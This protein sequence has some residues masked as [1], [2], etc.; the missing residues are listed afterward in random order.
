MVKWKTNAEEI[1]GLAR[2][3]NIMTFIII[4]ELTHSRT[5]QLEHI[6]EI[7]LQ[8]LAWDFENHS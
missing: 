1:V 8:P 4:S 7:K 3:V 2:R 5:N 6:R